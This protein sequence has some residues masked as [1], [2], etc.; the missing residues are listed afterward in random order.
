MRNFVYLAELH[1]PLAKRENNLVSA[2]ESLSSSHIGKIFGGGGLGLSPSPTI[3]HGQYFFENGISTW[4]LLCTVIHNHLNI[5]CLHY[6]SGM[7]EDRI[8]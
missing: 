3:D 8:R 5:Y 2:A 4:H 1:E 6:S 7:L